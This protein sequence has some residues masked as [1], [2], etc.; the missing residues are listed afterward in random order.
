MQY[1]KIHAERLGRS[2]CSQCSI[3]GTALFADLQHEDFEQARG[4]IEDLQL[5]ADAYLYH[6]GSAADA[7]FSLRSGVVKLVRYSP[8]GQQRVVRVL[9]AGDIVGLEA[10][11]SGAYG[12]AAQ[13]LTDIQLCRIP[14]PLLQTLEEAHP[15]LRHRIMQQWHV[16]LDKA[17]SWLAE[18]AGGQAPA[19]TRLARLMLQLRVSEK[20]PSNCGVVGKMGKASKG[21]S[22]NSA[23]HNAANHAA[24]HAT[25]TPAHRIVRMSLD[26]YSATLG[27]TIET[28]SRVLAVWQREGI[29]QR[30]TGN[31]RY[32]TADIARLRAEAGLVDAEPVKAAV[33]PSR[34]RK[35][36][37]ATHNDDTQEVAAA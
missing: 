22:A 1:T 14:L 30:E 15:I 12:N 21:E 36:A 35:V 28:V 10:L 3:R 8:E 27:L 33:K 37:A 6:M 34:T 29:V 18:L 20:A 26:D 9:K 7:V 19:R 16:A 24:Q 4:Q 25:S 11:V 13:A 31:R 23:A 17:D 32:Y 5:K 2:D